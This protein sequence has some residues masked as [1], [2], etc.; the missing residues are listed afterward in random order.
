MGNKLTKLTRN[1]EC[2]EAPECIICFEGFP[3]PNEVHVQCFVCN[4]YIHRQCFHR[5]LVVAKLTYCKCPYCR[6]VGTI[7]TQCVEPVKSTRRS[8]KKNFIIK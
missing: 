8:S 6:Q 2:R 7:T 3:D 4:K 1:T 5:Y